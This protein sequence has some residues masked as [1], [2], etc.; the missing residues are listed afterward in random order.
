[1]IIDKNKPFAC[2]VIDAL[3]GPYYVM[4]VSEPGVL[5]F[6]YILHSH[7][8]RQY[9]TGYIM[10]FIWLFFFFSEQQLK[11]RFCST[12]ITLLGCFFLL[13][14]VICF[15]FLSSSHPAHVF[16]YCFIKDTKKFCLS[17]SYRRIISRDVF[18]FL[19]FVAWGLPSLQSV[20]ERH[21]SRQFFSAFQYG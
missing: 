9:S 6:Q 15:S 7:S 17:S 2:F 5:N 10:F 20:G 13:I 4:F 16:I 14:R 11:V 3:I 12:Q 8:L 18:L 1:M 19:T 21:T